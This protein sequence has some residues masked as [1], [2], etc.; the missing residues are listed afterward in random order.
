MIDSANIRH[1]TVVSPSSTNRMQKPS[2]HASMWNAMA[3]RRAELRK[4]G[5]SVTVKPTRKVV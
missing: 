1:N 4:G 5:V 2:K 3:S